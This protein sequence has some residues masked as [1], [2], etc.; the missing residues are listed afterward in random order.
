MIREDKFLISRKPF[1]I[2]LATITGDQH[3]RGDRFAFSGRADAVWFRRQDGTNRACLGSIKLWSHYLPE[4]LDLGDPH[5]VLSADLDG[6]Y[7][8]DCYGRW[9]GHGYWGAEAPE[10]QQQHLS[11]L[12]PMLANYPAIPAGYDGW[13]TFQ[14]AKGKA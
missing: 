1:A 13:W 11:I 12:R 3:P 5:A 9:D 10:V 4:P 2:N 14:P 8:G 7:G 6:R